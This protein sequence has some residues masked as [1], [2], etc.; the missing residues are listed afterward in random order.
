MKQKTAL[1]RVILRKYRTSGKKE[2]GTILDDF[3]AASN[4]NRNYAA[5][6]LSGAFP[7]KGRKK[8][9][10]RKREYD[11][12]VYQKLHTIWIYADCICGKRLAPFLSEFIPI[13][14]RHQEIRLDDEVR[15]KL[16]SISASTIDRILSKSKK[17]LSIKGKSTTKPGSLL[18]HQIAIRTFA[19]WNENKPGFFEI[20]LVALCGGDASGE[21]INSLDMIDVCTGWV[22][23]AAFMGKSQYAVHKA[24]DK[25]RVQLYFKLLGLDSDNGT[26]FINDILYRYCI[27]FEIT[28]TRGRS[29][30]KNDGCFVEQKNYSVVRRFLGYARFD[31][32]EQL[33]IIQEVLLLIETYVNF[34]Q[35]V[36]KLQKKVR[37]GARVTRTYDK[38]KTPYQRLLET[39]TLTKSQEKVLQDIYQ[40]TNPVKL[41]R[42]INEL[43]K[44]LERTLVTKI[45]EAT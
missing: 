9:Y 13:L 8:K 21:F 25:K 14:E 20:D 12:F 36:L 31:T 24:I 10:K 2:K 43:L 7:K 38:A 42:K 39:K 15:E 33:K 27:K 18:K 30:K 34:F 5:K 1:S 4:Y 26:E 35:P 16:L 28:F 45:G 3:V 22:C 37:N 40:N 19:D 41:K 32:K 23:L 29:G 11:I 17:S 6:L 44:K